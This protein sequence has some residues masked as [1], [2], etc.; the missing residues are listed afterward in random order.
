VTDQNDDSYLIDSSDGDA[1]WDHGEDV[2][3]SG[4]ADVWGDH[5]GLD[6]RQPAEPHGNNG[7]FGGDSSHQ[8]SSD[9][10]EEFAGVNDG[11][12]VHGQ[13]EEEGEGMDNDGAGDF[14]LGYQQGCV[15][16]CG[17]RARG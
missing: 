14:D 8:Y 11:G 9:E 10:E 16:V 13:A 7:S 6:P 12:E 2:A 15:V 1:G 5:S 3:S 17:V 4:A